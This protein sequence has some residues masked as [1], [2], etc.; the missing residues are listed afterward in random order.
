MLRGWSSRLGFLGG[1][2]WT[3]AEVERF[4]EEAIGHLDALYRTALRLT[5]RPEDAEDL[6]QECYVRAFRHA[7]TFQPG[8]NLQ[9]WLLKILANL[10]LNQRRGSARRPKEAPTEELGEFLI[11]NRLVGHTGE[12]LSPSAEEQVLASFVEDDIR[13]ALEDLPE[14][15]RLA[16]LLSDVEGFSYREIAEMTGVPIGTVMSRLSRGRKLLQRSLWHYARE[17]GSSDGSGAQ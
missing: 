5:R 8:T 2:R 6:V 7:D 17:I 12:N 13:R 14:P 16:V 3:E 10:Y 1:G 15:F 11:Y 4:E 9:A